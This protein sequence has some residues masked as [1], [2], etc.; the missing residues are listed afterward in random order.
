MEHFLKQVKDNWVMLLFLGGVIVSWTTFNSRL[1][2]AEIKIVE[3]QILV[4]QI[5]KINI[6]IAV[7]RE[8]IININSKL[9]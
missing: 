8:Q 2:N 3:L 1:A 5:S 9:K 4:A 6:D 7:I